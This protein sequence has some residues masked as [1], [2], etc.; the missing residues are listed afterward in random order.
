MTHAFADIAF[1]PAVKLAQSRE[2]SRA[3]YAR[4]FERLRQTQNAR[5]G[6]TETEFIAAQRSFYMA[7][8]SETGWPYVQ[9][10]GGLPGFLKVLDEQTLAFADY[11][12]NRQLISVG[13]LSVDDRVA[14]ILVDYASRSRLKLLGRLTVGEHAA[15]DPALDAIGETSYGARVQRLMT[16]RLKGFD[17]NCSKHIPVRFEAEDVQR[18]LDE[19]DARIELLEARLRELQRIDP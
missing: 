18:A 13:N 6:E 1:T 12:G 2:G 10:R 15:G 14:L 3:S 5:L 11:A 16:I 4:G 8:V 19:R 7:T 9:H 17:W